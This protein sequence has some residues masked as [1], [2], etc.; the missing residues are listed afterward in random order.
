MR[1]KQ[2]RQPK[3]SRRWNK[4]NIRS[5]REMEIDRKFSERNREDGKSP[6]EININS[7]V[8]PCTE[9]RTPGSGSSMSL[10][11]KRTKVNL[12][13]FVCVIN[14]SWACISEWVCVCMC[15]CLCREYS[16]RRSPFADFSP[17]D[18]FVNSPIA[19]HS[20]LSWK[21]TCAFCAVAKMI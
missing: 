8:L 13:C 7:L 5:M 19:S 18:A 10:D 17:F 9:T 15:L 2:R 16:V 3:R 4:P 20:T 11:F 1:H 12:Y 6:S 21:S 14:L